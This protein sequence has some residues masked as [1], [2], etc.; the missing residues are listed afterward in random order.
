MSSRSEAVRRVVFTPRWFGLTILALVIVIAFIFFGR[1]QWQRTNDI[2]AAERLAA[3]QPVAVETITDTDGELVAESIGRPVTA[4]GRYDPNRQVSVTNRGLNG[5][6]GVWIV[7]AL[8]LDD[9]TLV[10]VIRGW[11]PNSATP[12]VEPPAERIEIDG[13][14]TPFETFYAAAEAGTEIAA[15]SEDVIRQ[16]WGSNTRNAVI[17]LQSQNPVTTPAPTP[18]PPTVT[19]ADVPFPWQNFFYAFQW[20]VFAGFVVVVWARW[21][22]LDVRRSSVAEESA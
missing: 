16:S 1:W 10:P 14:L 15:I 8:T 9:S 11:L 17:V 4:I 3:A 2:L 19:T 21:L 7:T 22:Q 6:S 20:W 12:G 5:V 18:V 13:V